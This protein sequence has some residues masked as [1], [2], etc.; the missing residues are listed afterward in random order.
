MAAPRYQVG[1]RINKW[2]VLR[3]IGTKPYGFKQTQMWVYELQCQC[4][5]IVEKFQHTM[6]SVRFAKHC[7]DCT[8][9]ARA[10]EL[11]KRPADESVKAISEI[12]QRAWR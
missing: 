8:A 12:N 6:N 5:T 9:K 4:G 7:P 1:S 2:T 11:A 10:E 3:V